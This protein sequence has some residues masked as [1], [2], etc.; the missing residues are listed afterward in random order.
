MVLYVCMISFKKLTILNSTWLDFNARERANMGWQRQYDDLGSFII[1]QVAVYPDFFKFFATKRSCCFLAIR[2]YFS[3]SIWK[4]RIVISSAL[5][6]KK[7][8][9]TQFISS[10]IMAEGVGGMSYLVKLQDNLFYA[11]RTPKQ[12]YEW[13]APTTQKPLAQV[14]SFQFTKCPTPWKIT[15]QYLWHHLKTSDK[16]IQ[17]IYKD[18]KL[19]RL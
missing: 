9:Q 18:N 17:S 13:I 2:I 7:D 12:V 15:A 4:P 11:R 10:T 5:R 14:Q 8:Y 3:K 6:D 19:E 1:L 16:K